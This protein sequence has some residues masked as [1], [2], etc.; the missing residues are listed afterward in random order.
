MAKVS[1]IIYIAG[2]SF[3]KRDY[4]R[5]GIET[6]K[7]NGFA[8][9]IW[10]LTPALHPD[11][12][13]RL[14]IQEPINFDGYR[15]FHTKREAAEAIS[16]LQEGS[17]IISLVFY[18]FNSYPIFRTISRKGIKYAMFVANVIPFVSNAAKL[19]ALWRRFRGITLE[20]IVNAVFLRL[21]FIYLGVRPAALLLAGGK[22]SVSRYVRY[23]VNSDTKVMWGHTLDYDIYLKERE[24]S[25]VSEESFGVFLDEDICFHRDYL[26]DKLAPFAT[27]GKYYEPLRNFFETLKA[28]YGFDVIVAAHPRSKYDPHQDYFGDRDVFKGKTIDLV[29]RSRFVVSHASTS[30]NYAVLFKKPILFIATD[31]LITSLQGRVIKNM[32]AQFNKKVINIS[33]N[34]NINWEEELS[35]D[36]KAYASYKESF[37]KRS[38]SEDKPFWQIFSDNIKALS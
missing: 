26:Y 17:F 33:E 1:K 4:D 25:L 28:K 12:Y 30:I 5:F 37:I 6:V 27:T 24:N 13:A 10:D 23:P 7:V 18:D 22:K 36:E 2:A 34:Y 20:R 29:R 38:I 31:E 21:P 32:A 14:G 3:C 8:V 16:L 19:S 35:I 15:I 9:E 11:I